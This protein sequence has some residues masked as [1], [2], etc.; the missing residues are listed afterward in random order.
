M[1]YMARVGLDGTLDSHFV[2]SVN[3]PV[4]SLSTDGS[5]I[6]FAGAFTSVNGDYRNNIAAVD[7]SGNLL[8]WHPDPHGDVYAIAVNGHSSVFVGGDFDSFDNGTVR[9]GY[10]A[11]LDY[12]TG[13][14]TMFENDLD[15]PARS[16]IINGNDVYVGGTFT[17]VDRH[18]PDGSPMGSTAR[19]S[20]AKFFISDGSM[21]DAWDPHPG[22]TVNAL[23]LDIMGDVVIG[24]DFSVSNN[25]NSFNNF[26][27]VDSIN[28][29][30][31]G[32]I[33]D[34]NAP[35]RSFA[36]DGGNLIYVGG[37]FTTIQGLPRKE[38]AAFDLGRSQ[39]T[40]WDPSPG[41]PV[42]TISVRGD[43]F[44]GG[45]FNMIGGTLR[46]N[47]AAIDVST[48]T[49]TSWDPN[50][51]GDIFS[52]DIL[53]GSTIYVAG[54]FSNI[55]GAG[56]NYVAALDISNGFASPWAPTLNNYAGGIRAGSN[57]IY[58]Y[59][60]LFTMVGGQARSYLASVNNTNGAVNAWNPA[61]NNNVND[62]IVDSSGIFVSG[63]F[64][65]IGGQSRSHL[66]LI[67][68]STGNATSWNAG[69][70]N[71]FP[72]KILLSGNTLYVGGDF[73]SIGGTTRNFLAAIDATT[74]SLSSWNPNL[75][76]LVNSMD[77]SE[78]T[79]YVGGS[80]TTIGGAS[81]NYIATIDT[82]SA[83]SGSFNP[84]EGY[85]PKFIY[86]RGGVL[87]VGGYGLNTIGN[88]FKTNFA[89]VNPDGSVQ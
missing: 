83:S 37:D 26:M 60:G 71:N 15:G 79:L 18:K 63:Y 7:S 81:R 1:S 57:S 68:A 13:S 22:G 33:A 54:T 36:S 75:N 76:N 42:R 89:V 2:V 41:L 70:F 53:Q 67:D 35:I 87:Y 30:A 43:I 11:E 3:G 86:S 50:A 55:G 88:T 46:N 28:G 49:V 39:I 82:S 78:G 16:I 44:V 65:T 52:M 6:F 80:F 19:A 32:M 72:R 51:N 9:R 56:R 29:N 5:N 4:V 12:T 21:S 85:P 40:G 84:N 64:S 69:A 14:P 48:G 73:T 27:I 59:G 58:I 38:L 62:V 66:A 61:P 25:S 77:I 24:G 10:L 23:L 20:A 8:P 17:S 47:L 34:A 31:Y 45:D 74:G